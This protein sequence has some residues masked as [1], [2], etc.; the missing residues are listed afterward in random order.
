MLR[1]NGGKTRHISASSRRINPTALSV[2]Q[3]AAFHQGSSAKAE[4]GSPSRVNAHKR[5][6]PPFIFKEA[7]KVSLWSKFPGDVA[8]GRQAGIPVMEWL[9]ILAQD[10]NVPAP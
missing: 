7:A 9:R 6:E 4:I 10:N 2:D 1:H 5:F 8:A 3:H